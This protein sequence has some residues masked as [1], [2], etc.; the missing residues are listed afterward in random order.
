V[1]QVIAAQSVAFNTA[2]LKAILE[3]NDSPGRITASQRQPA[4]SAGK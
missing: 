3:E 2:I 1:E 4:F